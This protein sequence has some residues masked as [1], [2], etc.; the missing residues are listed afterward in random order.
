MQ[1][2]GEK[3]QTATITQEPVFRVCGLPAEHGFGKDSSQSTQK[4]KGEEYQAD[5]TPLN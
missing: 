5:P 2:D 4:K 1:Q 3:G